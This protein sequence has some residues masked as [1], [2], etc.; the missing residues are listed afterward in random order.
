MLI[1]AREPQL[2]LSSKSLGQTLYWGKCL[3][4]L[5]GRSD[6]VALVGELG[7]GKTTLVQGMADGLGVD[8]GCYVTSPTFTIINEYKGRVPIY[9]LDFYR[10][11]STSE[12]E[13]LG[14][15]EYLL[16]DG[17]VL[18]EWAEKIEAFLPKEYLMISLEYV[19]YSVRKMSMRGIGMRYSEMVKAIEMKTREGNAGGIN[20]SE[21]WGNFGSHYR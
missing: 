2:V 18:I 12:V 10:I 17:V 14:L 13:N 7:T 21:I 6:V 5:L 15:E 20:R 1:G 11:D 9:H 4:R 3:G 19:D 8:K 16:G